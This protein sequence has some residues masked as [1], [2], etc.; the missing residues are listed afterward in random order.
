MCPP[1]AWHKIATLLFALSAV[2]EDGGKWIHGNLEGWEKRLLINK[3]DD[4]TNR[5]LK[6]FLE[7][8]NSTTVCVQDH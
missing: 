2:I 6:I 4:F 8:N 5:D 1:T 7:V 3:G